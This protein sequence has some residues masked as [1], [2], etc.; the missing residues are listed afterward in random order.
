MAPFYPTISLFLIDFFRFKI[1]EMAHI[2]AKSATSIWT[3][4]NGDSY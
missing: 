3:V 1:K 2:D 4:L